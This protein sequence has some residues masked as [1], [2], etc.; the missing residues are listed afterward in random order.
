MIPN[1][2]C[3]AASVGLAVIFLGAPRSEAQQTAPSLGSSERFAVLAGSTLTN[4]GSSTITGDI[5]VSPG[6]S[7]TGFPPGLV[8]GETHPADAVALAGQNAVTTVYNALGSQNCTDDLTGDNLGGLTLTPGVYCFSSSAQL[9]GILR[10]DAQQNANAVFIFRAG[11]TLTTASGSSVVILNGGSAC[12]VFWHVGS[13]ATLGTSTS[14]VGN[15]LAMASIT[16]TT[17][18]NLTGRALARSGAVTLDTNSVNASSCGGGG[19]PGP[20]P[21]PGPVPTLPTVFLLM[22]AAG[23]SA[24]GYL[25]LRRRS[26]VQ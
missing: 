15:I 2:Q 14:F 21:G 23:L 20:G 4:T 9:T 18:A 10:L 7:I 1:R 17:G 25:N 24:L 5:G 6:S 12:N 19:T 26:Q 11:S 16:M 13:S 22:L 3:L 8:T